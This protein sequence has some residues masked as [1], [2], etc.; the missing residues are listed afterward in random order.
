LPIEELKKLLESDIQTAFKKN[1]IL[2]KEV[3]KAVKEAIKTTK[4]KKKVEA[5]KIQGNIQSK[6]YLLINILLILLLG[7]AMNNVIKE[8]KKHEHDV[9]KLDKND[10]AHVKKLIETEIGKEAHKKEIE[11]LKKDA[12]VKHASK[13]AV[14]Q[15]AAKEKAKGKKKGGKHEVPSIR[16]FFLLIQFLIRD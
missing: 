2:E 5:G 8:M 15:E 14:H 1:E 11:K 16:K 4:N 6:S 12:E 9:G 10:K 3:E 7:T 13:S